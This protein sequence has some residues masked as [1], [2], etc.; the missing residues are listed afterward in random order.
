MDTR[1]T[2]AILAIAI[3]MVVLPVCTQAIPM[4]HGVAGTVYLSDGVTQAPAGTSF[5]LTTSVDHK[6]D[7]TGGATSGKY[8]N[9]INGEDGDP[10][11]VYAW[12]ATHYG[13]NTTTLSPTQ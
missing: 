2:D 7:T 5:N 12:N 9:S 4:P 13:V 11:T 1:R 8:V 3:I 6:E 10:V